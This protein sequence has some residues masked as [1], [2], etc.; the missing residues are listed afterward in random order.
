M[1]IH[2]VA[3]D[4]VPPPAS[5]ERSLRHFGDHGLVVIS[6]PATEAV[7]WIAQGTTLVG[8]MM[9][10]VTRLPYSPDCGVEAVEKLVLI[11]D[12]SDHDRAVG[13]GIDRDLADRGLQRVARDLDAVRVF[14]NG[15]LEATLDWVTLVMDC[16][17][18]LTNVCLCS[19]AVSSRN[20]GHVSKRVW[21]INCRL[22][23]Q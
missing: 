7:P 2:C 19:A 21:P 9:P 17:G 6:R 11:H 16:W 14:L 5:P 4:S 3:A 1:L 10:L 15:R 13:A 8:S 23:P 12:L 22:Q 18:D 20:D